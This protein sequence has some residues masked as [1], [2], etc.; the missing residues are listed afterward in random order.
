MYPQ[1]M[2]KQKYEKY[3]NFSSEKYHFCSSEKL[4]YITLARFRTGMLIN[5]NISVTSLKKKQF[6][7]FRPDLTQTRLYEFSD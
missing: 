2:F 5:V 3:H 4:Q 6:E 1:S 7:C